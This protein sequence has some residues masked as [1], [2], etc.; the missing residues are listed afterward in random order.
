MIGCRCSVWF[1]VTTFRLLTQR[2]DDGWD[3][4]NKSHEYL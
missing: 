1:G 3:M 4:V 2:S